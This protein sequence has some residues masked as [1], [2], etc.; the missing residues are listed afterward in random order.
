MHAKKGS[1]KLLAQSLGFTAEECEEQIAIW[2]K[3]KA[4]VSSSKKEKAIVPSPEST[5]PKRQCLRR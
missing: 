4:I 2:K 5:R 3:E 1:E